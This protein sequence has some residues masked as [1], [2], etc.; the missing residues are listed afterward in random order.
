MLC[1]LKPKQ[2]PISQYTMTILC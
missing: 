1:S 2:Q